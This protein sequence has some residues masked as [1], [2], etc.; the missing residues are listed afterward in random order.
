MLAA[1]FL[2]VVLAGLVVF[3]VVSTVPAGGPPTLR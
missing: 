3:I 1:A 2:V